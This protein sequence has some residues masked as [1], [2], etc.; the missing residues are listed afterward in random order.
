MY[1]QT[2]RVEA[3]RDALRKLREKL[4]LVPEP[5]K[6]MS[7]DFHF[8]DMELYEEFKRLKLFPVKGGVPD[9]LRDSKEIYEV[10]EGEWRGARITVYGPHIPNPDYQPPTEEEL[11]M[12]SER[13]KRWVA[14]QQ[15]LSPDVARAF[16][17]AVIRD[18][19]KYDYVKMKALFASFNI[20]F[21]R[22]LGW[23]IRLFAEAVEAGGSEEDC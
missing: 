15:L 11:E 19:V 20:D 9:Y 1:A 21:D 2:L 3:I 5:L 13:Y 12:D 17:E 8:R 16:W 7:I 6:G 14:K 10:L 22:A 18:V 23:A 4:S